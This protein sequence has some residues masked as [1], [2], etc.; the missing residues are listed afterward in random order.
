MSEKYYDAEAIITVEGKT[1]ALY[2][3]GSLKRHP[4]IIDTVTGQIPDRQQRPIMKSYLRQNGVQIKENWNTHWCIRQ[5][6]SIA[7]AKGV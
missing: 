5:A 6:I 7:N 2:K 4:Y 3:N 1:Y